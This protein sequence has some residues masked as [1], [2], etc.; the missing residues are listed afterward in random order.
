MKNLIKKV[1]WTKGQG[2][3]PAVIQDADTSAVLMLGYMNKE[4]FAKTLKTKKVWFYS[5]S[6]QRLWMKGETS[7]NILNLV[8]IKLDCDNDAILIKAKPVG[9][10]CHTGAYSCFKENSDSNKLLELYGV[11]Q[12]RKLKM[13][14][15]SYTASLFK[16]GLDKISL[17]VAEEALEVVHAAQKQTKTRLIEETVDL[18]YHLFVLLTE[19]DISFKDITDE[20]DKR[21]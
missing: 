5:R 3:V 15:K 12:E 7:K 11:I 21:R 8:D 9:P 19:K 17:K 20:I 13:P 10:T 14:K 1:N 16:A 6:R 2:L 18:I 4:S